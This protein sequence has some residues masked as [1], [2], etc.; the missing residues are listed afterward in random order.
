MKL[1]YL[2]KGL[3]G[4][5]LHPPLTDA[6]SGIHS[7][8]TILLPPATTRHGLCSTCV[9]KLVTYKGNKH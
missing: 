8:A 9:V 1:S 5:P 4:H 6:T 2:V 7:G 3:P